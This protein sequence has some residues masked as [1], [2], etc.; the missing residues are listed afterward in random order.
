MTHE[1]PTHT[2]NSSTADRVEQRDRDTPNWRRL[3]VAATRLGDRISEGIAAAT[4]EG[5]DVDEAT[6]RCLANVLGRSLGANS[7]LSEYGR[8]GPATTRHSATNISRCTTLQTP[9]RS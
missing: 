3:E 4:S 6:S 7:A 1:N 2:I 8:S 9:R 5:R